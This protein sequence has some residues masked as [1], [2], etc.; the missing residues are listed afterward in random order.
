MA[1]LKIMLGLTIWL[2]NCVQA[3]MAADAKNLTQT[4][5]HL[6]KALESFPIIK[7]GQRLKSQGEK[8]QNWYRGDKK[9]NLLSREK[10]TKAVLEIL[11]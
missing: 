7:E 1:H 11:K 2:E 9:M 5:I 4:K 8:W 6:Q 10:L 3:K